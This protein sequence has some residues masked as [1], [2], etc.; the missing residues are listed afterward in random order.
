MHLLTV[1]RLVVAQ[2]TTAVKEV[3]GVI[4]RWHHQPLKKL[5][6]KKLRRGNIWQVSWI[7]LKIYKFHLFPCSPLDIDFFFTAFDRF[8]RTRSYEILS[9]RRS[10]IS[11][12]PFPTLLMSLTPA[13]Y[14]SQP[15]VR[16]RRPAALF[17]WL[18][19]LVRPQS[20]IGSKTSAYMQVSMSL[21]EPNL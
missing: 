17:S 10:M 13:V 7:S 8:R 4:S 21:F 6:Q 19:S 2:T 1:G 20:R 5:L 9:C 18:C 15:S 11:F 16:N 14:T 12:L 3:T